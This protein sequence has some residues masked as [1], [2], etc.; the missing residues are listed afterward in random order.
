MTEDPIQLT[1]VMP[2]YNEAHILPA[3]LARLQ[4]LALPVSWELL[5]VDDGSTDGSADLV[6]ATALPVARQV[7]V[8]RSPRNRG[9]GAAL[10]RGFGAAQGAL[11]AVQDADLEYDPADLPA[12]LAPLLDG[13]ADVVFGSRAEAGYAPFS[14]LY[15][16][17]NQLLGFVAALLFGRRVT[18]IYTGYKLVT[19]AA[20]ERLRL[21]ADGFDI[22][23]EI[24]GQLFLTGARIA[25]R[26]ISYVPRSRQ[27]G[28]KLY[29]RDG[30]T[31]LVRLFRV[32][33]GRRP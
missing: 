16:A 1:L 20:Y 2:V 17:G 31:G 24:A 30:V 22:E 10:R 29:A 21:S 18:D 32:R 3:T 11:L 15:A 27:E 5:V 23:A 4:T 28:K 9:K 33:F 19:R 14:R 6:S 26:P 25:E 13:S 7:R 8:L 12:L